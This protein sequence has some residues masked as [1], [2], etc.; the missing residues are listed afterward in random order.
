M[1]ESTRDI[2]IRLDEQT[3]RI[4]ADLDSEKGTRAR[5]NDDIRTQL[6][7]QTTELKSVLATQA[8]NTN[9]NLKVLSEAQHATDNKL[10]TIT[11][12]GML[13]IITLQVL[14]SLGILTTNKKTN[15]HSIGNRTNA[16]SPGTNG[17]N[18][19]SEK[20][21]SPQGQ[22]RQVSAFPVGG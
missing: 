19:A 1:N 15:E 22:T 21:G 11:V 20:S 16:G 10:A 14:F 7:A 12:V 18:K 4:A 2:V 3:K 9:E 17:Q 13:I 8:K 5:A 6:Q